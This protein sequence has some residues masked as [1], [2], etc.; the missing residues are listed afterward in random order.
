M[1]L[2]LILL[3]CASSVQ[4]QGPDQMLSATSRDTTLRD[5]HLDGKRATPGLQAR[6]CYYRDRG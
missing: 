2:A 4:A 5:P 3:T 1:L 6:H